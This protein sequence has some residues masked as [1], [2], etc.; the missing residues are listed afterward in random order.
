MSACSFLLFAVF[1]FLRLRFFLIASSKLGLTL[2]LDNETSLSRRALYVSP[3]EKVAKTATR[4]MTRRRV[5][6]KTLLLDIDN[7][8][9][10]LN[11]REVT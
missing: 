9:T 7:V 8:T 5:F 4:H 11:V 3:S 2:T 1:F 6:T 10:D